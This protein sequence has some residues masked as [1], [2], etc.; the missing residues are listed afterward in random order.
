[1]LY[2]TGDW[3]VLSA[4]LTQQFGRSTHALARAWLGK[5]LGIRI[6]PWQKDPQGIFMGGNNM[7]LS[8]M[9]TLRFGE[10]Y[11]NGGLYRG[12]RLLAE[13]WIR[14]S[15]TPRTRSAS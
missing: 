13:S 4:I 5:P 2:S 11:R 12:K 7:L 1:M 8:P 9:A 10:L 6:P 3:H 14:A 15:W